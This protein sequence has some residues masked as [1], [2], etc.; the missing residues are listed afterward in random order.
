M[1]LPFQGEQRANGL[2]PAAHR[3]SPLVVMVL[4]SMKAEKFSFPV[5][6]GHVESPMLG[7]L[8]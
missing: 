3:D 7:L 5:E 1:S 2:R 6:A 8:G 4:E